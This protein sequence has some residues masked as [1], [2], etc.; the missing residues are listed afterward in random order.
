MTEKTHEL[1]DLTEEEEAESQALTEALFAAIDGKKLH[2]AMGVLA[3]ALADLI[4]DTAEGET[5]EHLCGGVAYTTRALT[6]RA[7]ETWL[8]AAPAEARLE[9]AMHQEA[10]A[11]AVGIGAQ[12]DGR[13]PATVMSALS[14]AVS[15]AIAGAAEVAGIPRQVIFAQFMRRV[16]Q[17]LSR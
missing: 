11:V 15:G 3:G 16:G 14:G 17:Q 6:E 12:L 2:V 9:Q 10:T 1:V 7:L 5:F 4:A 13:D 8:A